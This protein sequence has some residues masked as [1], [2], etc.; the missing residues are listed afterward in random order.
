MVLQ[1]ARSILAA[2]IILPILAMIAVSL[3]VVARKKKALS[4]RSDDWTIVLSLVVP[5]LNLH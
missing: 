5:L 2:S 1:G 3:R 4:L